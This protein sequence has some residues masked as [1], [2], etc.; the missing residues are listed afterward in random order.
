MAIAMASVTA[1]AGVQPLNAVATSS[2]A[3]LASASR[4]GG[5]RLNNEGFSL[6]TTGRPATV[7]VRAEEGVSDKV[8]GAAGEASREVKKAAGG[9]QDKLQGFWNFF[10]GKGAK[11]QDSAQA[12]ARDAEKRAQRVGDQAADAS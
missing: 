10:S 7:V 4:L 1:A 11:A 2:H 6:R 12:A 9:L 5:F 3:H 8:Q